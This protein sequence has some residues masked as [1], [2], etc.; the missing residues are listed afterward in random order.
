MIRPF[1]NILTLV[2]SQKESEAYFNAAIQISNLFD[3]HLHVLFRSPSTSPNMP[4]KQDDYPFEEAWT[5]Q[6]AYRSVLKPGL[7]L[8]IHLIRRHSKR[9]TLTYVRKNNIDLVL[10]WRGGN[11]PLTWLPTLLRYNTLARDLERPVLILSKDVII[12]GLSNI[13]LPVRHFLPAGKMVMAVRLAK[14]FNAK[15]HLVGVQATSGSRHDEQFFMKACQLLRNNTNITIECQLFKNLDVVWAVVKYGVK[16]NAD[17]ILSCAGTLYL[18][19]CVRRLLFTPIAN[20]V[21]KI[22]VMII[23]FEDLNIQ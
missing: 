19:R 18:I 20:A 4:A 16:V 21:G 22:P 9:A 13:I 1:M 11:L 15:I 8:H 23:P 6:N 2:D 17:I 14:K 12:S 5:L 3:C 7:S 10:G